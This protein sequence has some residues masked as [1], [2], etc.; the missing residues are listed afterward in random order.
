[1]NKK[2]ILY[3]TGSRADFGL[4]KETLINLNKLNN[5]KVGLVVT[6]QHLIEKYGNTISEIEISGI[7]IIGKIPVKLNGED[8]ESVPLAISKQIKGMISIFSEWNPDLILLLGDR[9]EMLAGAIAASYSLVPI[10]HIHGGERSGTIDESIRHAI[11]KLANIHLVAT[12]Q[13][14]ERLIKMGEFKQ[15]IIVTG[16][17]GLD[18][19]RIKK[20]TFESKKVFC[21]RYDF[22]IH[23][24]IITLLFHPVLQEIQQIKQNQSEIIKGI[25]LLSTENIY[26]QLLVLSPNSDAGG[27]LINQTWRQEL[28]KLNLRSKYIKHLPREE[29]LNALS[30]SNVL[31]GNSSSG[32]IESASFGIPVINLGTRQNARE[33]NLNV[34]TIN[35]EAFE[36]QKAL[37]E[38]LKI[39]KLKSHNLYGDGF[40]SEKIIKAIESININKDLTYKINSY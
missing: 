17:P 2:K 37:S 26:P 18:E 3:L 10:V 21:E 34:K 16:A 38:S 20:D 30:N 9:G 12:K 6:G 1:M 15:N 13:S 7:E 14:K 28:A 11:S 31:L 33:K 5:F 36:I 29:Y 25:N 24:P 39:K 23:K 35:L 40:A 8:K 22:E 4:I 27:E 19:I 32:I